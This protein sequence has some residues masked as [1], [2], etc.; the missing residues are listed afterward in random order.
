MREG[1]GFRDWL[2]ESECLRYDVR[3]GFLSA[4]DFVRQAYGLLAEVEKSS[5]VRIRLHLVR[6]L[7]AEIRIALAAS[8]S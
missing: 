5:D 8:G 7:E 6:F 2:S 4:S 1:A 3:R